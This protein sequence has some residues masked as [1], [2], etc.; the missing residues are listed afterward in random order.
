VYIST[1]SG[2]FQLVGTILG[3][4]DYVDYNSTTAIGTSFV[5]AEPIGGDDQATVYQFLMEIKARLPKHRKRQ[6]K[7]IANGIGY[8]AL[9]EMTDFDIWTYEDKL[10]KQYRIKQNVS[11][12][13]ATTDMAE[14]DV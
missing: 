7:F 3:S 9:Q 13:G 8:V 6:V 14:P 10:P 1:D 5:G 12:D 4:G 11:V 2:D